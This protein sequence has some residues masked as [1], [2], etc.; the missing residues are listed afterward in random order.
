MPIKFGF[1]LLKARKDNKET[2]GEK[3]QC[4]IRGERQ[5]KVE[6][7]ESLIIESP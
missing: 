5:R 3:L 6:V 4:F 7:R 2:K 1:L